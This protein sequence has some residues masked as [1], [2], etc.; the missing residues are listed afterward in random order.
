M[1]LGPKG[2]LN[3]SDKFP[4]EVFNKSNDSLLILNELKNL[5]FGGMRRNPWN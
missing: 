5:G 3:T 4:K 2:D 1:K